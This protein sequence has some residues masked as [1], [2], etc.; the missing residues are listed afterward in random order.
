MTT[1]IVNA[2]VGAE[3]DLGIVISHDVAATVLEHSVNK[4]HALKKDPSY[5]PILVRTELHDY[6]MRR[7]INAASAFGEVA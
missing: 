6:Y 2:I 7:A 5:L 3:E 4:C 1:G